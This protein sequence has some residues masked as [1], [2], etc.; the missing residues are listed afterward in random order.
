ML[1]QA[2]IWYANSNVVFTLKYRRKNI[3]NQYHAYL[4]E[5]FKQFNDVDSIEGHLMPKEAEEVRTNCGCI[6]FKNFCT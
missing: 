1:I 4:K 2:I 3:Y 6:C 5:V